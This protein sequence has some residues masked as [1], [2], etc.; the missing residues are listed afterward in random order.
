MK[1]N[2]I[3]FLSG[4]NHYSLK[5]T[6]R[7][8]LD[9]G[10]LEQTP[11]NLLPGFADRLLEVIP[12]L[13]SHTCSLGYPGGF[14][15]RLREG[16]WMGHILEHIALELQHLA[17]IPVKRGKTITASK[18]GIYYVTFDYVEKESGR[19]AFE[20]A[21]TIVEALLRGERDVEA[22]A[23]V[24]RIA[25]L[26]Y[27]NKLGPS[28]EAIYQAAL[29]RKIP[30]ERIGPD[31]LLRLGTGARQKR[32]QATITSQTSHLAVE[33]SCDKEMTKHLLEEAGLPV[34]RGTVI[35]TRDELAGAA[36]QLGYPLVL[37]PLSG[38]QGQGVL[39]NL[40][41][42]DQLLQAYDFVRSEFPE[43]DV[44]I[45]ERYC[46]GADYR[47]TVVNG[48]AAAVSLR[49]PPHVT[50]DGQSSVLDLIM[51]ENGNPLRGEGHEKPMSAI[52]VEQA[53]CYLAKQGISLDDIPAAGRTLSVM[54]SANLS[55]GGSA[56][57]VTDRVHPSYLHIAVQAARVIGLDIAG[58]DL[59]CGDIEAPYQDG[60]ACI[61]E[62]NAAPGIRMH[63][64]PSQ[65][66]PRDVGGAIVDYLF[67][68]RSS[69]AVPLIAVTGTN[70]KT[71][72]VRLAAHMLNAAG[73]RVGMTCSDGVWI[74]GECVD[75]GDCSGPGSARRVLSSPD[76]DAAVLETARGG[77]MR[78]GLAF[79]YCDVGIVTNVTEDHLGMDGIETL[80]DL[81]KLKRLI[82]EV[83]LPGGVCVLNAD[84]EGCVAMSEYTDG[85]VVYFSL[86][87]SNPVLTDWLAMG[88]EAWYLSEGWILYG[89][90]GQTVRFAKA[91]DLPV[92]IGGLAKHNIANALAA[93][94][95]ARGLG[96]SI[97]QLGEAVM[98][99]HPT[100]EQSKGRFNMEYVAGRVLITDYGHNPAGLNAVYE[101]VQAIPK[102]RLITV[103]S[104]PGDRPDGAIAEMGRIAG[105]HSDF[106]VIKEDE[107]L[108]GRQPLESAALLEAG[109]LQA[110]MPAERTHIIPNEGEAYRAAWEMSDF[111]DVIL[112]FYEDFNEVEAFLAWLQA[113]DSSRHIR[114][115]I[116]A[117]GM[118]AYGD[119]A[120]DSAPRLPA[121]SGTYMMRLMP[122]RLE[123]HETP[124][125]TLEKSGE[126]GA[127]FPAAL[128]PVETGII[129]APPLSV[130]S[131]R[132][133]MEGSRSHD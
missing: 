38:R 75:E 16:T 42:P 67:E 90:G 84:D 92:T 35:R 57:D 95:A 126:E 71:T 119:F 2:N 53:A 7:V 14:V 9:I 77:I 21:L 114:S 80:E 8:E 44:F 60:R 50:G 78:E 10:N 99:F 123:E 94:A 100:P 69:A 65:G 133:G 118:R 40:Q 13:A 129:L 41:Q 116:P 15:E 74:N 6:I 32:V 45:L 73:S 83:V 120:A 30:V 51:R 111:G 55:T 132:H 3:K 89:T 68:S 36:E 101:A 79:R 96:L 106:F 128:G 17:G 24:S 43:Y 20:S 52:P 93:L 105:R 47:F 37:K 54:G 61:L 56:E 121:G 12:S 109:A 59:I 70:G 98:T 23:Y 87:D 34:P 63:H 81:R 33:A 82:P 85:R 122:P 48:K 130:S 28:T 64:Y 115:R 102:Q 25:E 46:E 31:S 86:N 49:R 29:A 4:P 110:G 58:I 66:E 125:M 127:G 62:V 88:G 39:T 22:D 19:C 27:T 112:M 108:R 18:P 117:N 5:P 97:R 104:A 107:D 11:S 103:A 113:D 26:Y 124:L 91:A 1:V 76:I 131:R 72:T